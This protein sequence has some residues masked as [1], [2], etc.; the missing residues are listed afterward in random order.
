MAP[1]ETEQKAVLLTAL[2]N[3]P[4]PS[5]GLAALRSSGRLDAWYPELQGLAGVAQSPLHH[6]EGDVWTHTMLVVDYAS[7]IKA[8]AKNPACFLLAALCHDLGKPATTTTDDRGQIHAYGHDEVGAGVARDFLTRIGMD[9]EP[10]KYV[11]NMVAL[12]MQ[13]NRKAKANAKVKSTNQMFDKSVCPEDLL[14]LAEADHCGKG[15][16]EP[17]GE[18]RAWLRQRLQVYR[19]T[20]AAPHV[21]EQDLIELDVSPGAELEAMLLLAHKLQLSGNSRSAVVKQIYAM[22]RKSGRARR[23]G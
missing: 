3:A 6:P 18:T 23:D 21:T 20:M 1:R 2:L 22:I 13:P 4:K 12:H 14:L 19:E 7:T 9:E 8:Q 17:Y 15:A 5:D 10:I 16:H 11:E